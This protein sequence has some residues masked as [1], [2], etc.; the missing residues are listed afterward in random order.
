MFPTVNQPLAGNVMWLLGLTAALGCGPRAIDAPP[1]PR[2]AGQSSMSSADRSWQQ[3]R[4]AID[5][6]DWTTAEQLVG[7]ML[8]A[9]G[10]DPE[11]L[12][13]AAR[14][15]F[16]LKDL[17]T[18]ADLLVQACQLTDF[19]DLELYHNAFKTLL[20]GGYL[21]EAIELNRQLVHA[22]PDQL[23]ALR[24]LYDVLIDAER[25]LEVQR[26]GERLIERRQFD[27][28]MLRGLSAWAAR[29]TESESLRS[30][31]ERNPLDPRPLVGVAKHAMDASRLDEAI[32]TLQ[33]IR[34]A[35]PDDPVTAAY[36]AACYEL[37]A[38]WTSLRGLLRDA[39]P[40]AWD[41]HHTLL[42]TAAL[43]ERDGEIGVA[44]LAV[45]EAIVINPMDLNAHRRLLRLAGRSRPRGIGAT[46][47]KPHRLAVGVAASLQAF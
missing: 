18:S 23:T 28:A 21:F 5:A 42:A 14:I 13:A 2:S 1:P 30:I 37:T 9:A 41:Y 34:Q 8:I 40:T 35:S 24:T 4:G 31:V 36:L 10:E 39:P 26:V 22:R 32:G 38:D 12:A 17:R 29:T 6:K 19:K 44:I 11:L 27:A 15:R 46:S 47:E 25:H 20:A 33:T 16:E 7:P 3:L 45:C 43:A